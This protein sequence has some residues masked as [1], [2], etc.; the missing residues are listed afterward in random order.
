MIKSN[1]KLRKRKN[2]WGKWSKQF[3]NKW[4]V[5]KITNR[6]RE[7]VREIKGDVKFEPTI[8]H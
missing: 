7:R 1:R 4:F 5:E 3:S 8:T 2:N 6:R